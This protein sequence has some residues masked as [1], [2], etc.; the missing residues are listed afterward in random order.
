MEMFMHCPQLFAAVGYSLVYL[1]GGGGLFGAI[2]IFIVA[3]M[4]GQ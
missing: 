4:F 2:V 3:K 1:L